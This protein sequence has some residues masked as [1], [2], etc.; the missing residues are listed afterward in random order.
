MN[1]FSPSR[2][3]SPDVRG[4]PASSPSSSEQSSERR[5]SIPEAAPAASLGSRF[6]A[7]GLNEP[8]ARAVSDEGYTEPTPIQA[9]TIPHL[10]E[11]RDLL[12]CAQTG[13]GKTAAFVLPML[14]HLSSRTRSGHVRALVVAPTREL[15]LQIAERVSVYGRHAQIRHAVIYG[16]VGQRAQEQALARRPDVVIATPGRLLDLMSQQLVRLANVEIFVL[17]EADRMLDMGFIHDIRRVIAALPRKR[18]TLL[19]SATLPRDIVSL[20]QSILIEPL[21]VSVTPTVRT[22]DGI[23]QCVHFVERAGKRALLEHVLRDASVQRALVFTRTKRGAERVSTQLVRSG[24]KAAAIHGNKSQSARERA[25]RDFRDGR[26]PVLVATDVASRGIDVDDISHVVNYDLPHVAEDYV[27]RVGRTGRAGAT[28]CAV[29]FCDDEER[30]QL[31]DIERLLAR[32][33]P[34]A[35]APGPFLR[36]VGAQRSPSSASPRQAPASAPNGSSSGA[37]SGLRRSWKPGRRRSRGR[38]PH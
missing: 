32:R 33:I 18:Q 23:E 26:V 14:Q 27:H 8:F 11:G 12:G 1:S 4:A 28:G 21:Q 36:G 6:A 38:Q 24:I 9:Q 16:G 22:A 2:L 3:A 34:L 30:S 5:P 19:F 20:A 25:L 15:A 37:N 35:Q 31:R 7:L 10:L 13:T 29:S 17:D